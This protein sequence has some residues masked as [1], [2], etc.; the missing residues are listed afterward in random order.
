MRSGPYIHSDYDRQLEELRAR[1]AACEERENKLRE[2]LRSLE[3]DKDSE[4][5]EA[6]CPYCMTLDGELHNAGCKMAEAMAQAAA[7]KEPTDGK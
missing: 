3:W 2:I 4:D 1:L 5:E 7:L 6:C